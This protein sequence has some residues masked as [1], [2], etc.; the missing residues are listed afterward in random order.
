MPDYLVVRLNTSGSMVFPNSFCLGVVEIRP[1][2]LDTQSER[3]ALENSVAENDEK[4]DLGLN[5]RLCTIVK[6]ANSSAD[7][8]A[9]AQ[10]VFEEVLDVLS[11]DSHGL[12]RFSLLE[13]GFTRDLSTG[14]IEHKPL[15]STIPSTVFKI[16]H[17]R[18]PVVTIKE[19][20]LANK[21]VDLCGR[22]LRS[23]HWARHAKND[24]KLQMNILFHWFAMEALM[25][26]DSNDNIA[27]KGLLAL[28]FPV[29]QD[30]NRL[31]KA[32]I[33][34]LKSHPQYEIY[35]K[36]LTKTMEDIREYRN[37]SVHFGFR[38]WDVPVDELRRNA[39]IT[40]TACLRSQSL[41]V[42]AIKNGCKTLNDFISNGP[43]LINQDKNIV[44]YVHNTFLY[45]LLNK[46]YLFREAGGRS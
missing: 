38:Q 17:E 10:A 34:S 8:H 20:L 6:N 24:K 45:S 36:L 12:A 11:I 2:K 3:K 37:N 5:T 40:Q 42:I 35:K 32:I 22:L 29:G 44:N 16:Q 43:H 14:L 41:A 15:P 21:D 18:Y 7:A 30:V 39:Y 23:L 26:A 33:S 46:S 4:A 1:A 13:S 19:H 9:E 31:D 28:G 27:S 25:K